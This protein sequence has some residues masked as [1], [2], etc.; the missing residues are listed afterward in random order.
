MG[1]I[2]GIT[3]LEA[4]LTPKTAYDELVEAFLGH[5]QVRWYKVL[6]LYFFQSDAVSSYCFMRHGDASY[7]LSIVSRACHQAAK[8]VHAP[9][10]R[11]NA[12]LRKA[13][14]TTSVEAGRP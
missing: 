14:K 3:A 4:R 12:G 10:C 13:D 7:P 5:H 11:G 1:S 6:P 2:Y 9:G 8:R